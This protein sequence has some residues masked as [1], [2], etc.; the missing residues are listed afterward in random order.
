MKMIRSAEGNLQARF[1]TAVSDSR[2][3]DMYNKYIFYLMIDEN[4]DLIKALQ[5]AQREVNNRPT[6]QSYDLLAWAYYNM[7]RKEEAFKIAKSFVENRNYEPERIISFRCDL[8]V[9]RRSKKGKT[10]YAGS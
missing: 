8:C 2:Y 3:G 7:G 6:S 10:F 9:Y 1:I 4:K 5:I